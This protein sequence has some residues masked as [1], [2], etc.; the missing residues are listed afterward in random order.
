MKAL[1]AVVFVF[2]ISINS[3][4]QAAKL[5]SPDSIY[6]IVEQNPE[7]PGGDA[8]LMKFLTKNI[9]YPVLANNDDFCGK[10]LMRFVIDTDG[11][12]INPQIIRSCGPTFDKEL[13]RVINLLPKFKP[14]YQNGKA[15][16]V[17]FNLPIVFEPNR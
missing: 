12:V 16:K 11:S 2:L 3:N 14:G 9:Q 6:T 1:L 15:V 4:A 10:I 17:Y 7:C 13:L 5:S 8:A